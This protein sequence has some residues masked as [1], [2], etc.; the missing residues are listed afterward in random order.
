LAAT[1]DTSGR[2]FSP[3][4]PKQVPNVFLPDRGYVV[5]SGGNKKNVRHAC[6]AVVTATES[7]T[8]TAG[9]DPNTEPNTDMGIP[10]DGNAHD[11]WSGEYPTIS[12]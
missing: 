12:K 1:Y 9:G 6:G 10:S 11:G 4:S 5:G 2:I 3:V 7:D 8:T